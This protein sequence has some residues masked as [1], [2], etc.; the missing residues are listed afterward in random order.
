MVSFLGTFDEKQAVHE[1]STKVETLVEYLKA[2]Y[3]D[4]AAS[5]KL[6]EGYSS[7][8]QLSTFDQISITEEGILA[9][10]KYVKLID[11]KYIVEK[12]IK[13]SAIKRVAMYERKLEVDPITGEVTKDELEL[14]HTQKTHI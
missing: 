1:N 13:G 2:Q 6:E 10:F 4:E 12:T 7:T 3:L 11:Q 8:N 5:A 9:A 14:P